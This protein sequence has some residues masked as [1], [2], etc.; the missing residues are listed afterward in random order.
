MEETSKCSADWR[1][2]RKLMVWTMRVCASVNAASKI[3]EKPASLMTTLLKCTI[4]DVTK[5]CPLSCQVEQQALC[6]S[7]GQIF[8]DMG[9][10]NSCQFGK[11][12]HMGLCNHLVMKVTM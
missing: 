8:L 11:E 1:H 7:L 12:T 5:V 6:Q 9:G 3:L 4:N 10:G 2:M